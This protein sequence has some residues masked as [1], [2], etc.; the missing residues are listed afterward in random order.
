MVVRIVVQ[1][2]EARGSVGLS[3]HNIQGSPTV[4]GGTL[5][6]PEKDGASL[7]GGDVEVLHNEGLHVVAVGLDYCKVVSLC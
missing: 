4:P 3:G 2:R 6:G 5:V 7:A 1:Y